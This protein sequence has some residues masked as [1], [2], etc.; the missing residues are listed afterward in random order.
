[1]S[2]GRK[3]RNGIIFQADRVEVSEPMWL[4]LNHV[5]I[6]CANCQTLSS[7]WP[8][9]FDEKQTET[10]RLYICSNIYISFGMHVHRELKKFYIML[11]MSDRKYVWGKT[12]K[13][14]VKNLILYNENE[15]FCGFALLW[16]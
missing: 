6:V 11:N 9:T 4:F 12:K 3:K 14:I 15:E 5:D 1:M 8:P 16:R 13:S 7:T 10:N 2:R